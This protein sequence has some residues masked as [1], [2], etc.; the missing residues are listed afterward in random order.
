[1]SQGIVNDVLGQVVVVVIRS[2]P[3]QLS[4]LSGGEK[5]ISSFVR[6]IMFLGYTTTNNKVYIVRGNSDYFTGVQGTVWN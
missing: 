5:R 3:A 6:K 1:M 2:L 4:D